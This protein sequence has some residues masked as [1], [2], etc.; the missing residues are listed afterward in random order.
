MPD[1]NVRP[2][3]IGDF[4]A[5]IALWRVSEGVGLNEYLL[6][7]RLPNVLQILA[8]AS[9][10]VSKVLA[11]LSQ[12]QRPIRAASHHI[13]ILVILTVILPKADWTNLE[14]ASLAQRAGTTART[15]IQDPVCM[16]FHDGTMLKSVLVTIEPLIA[17]FD[18]LGAWLGIAHSVAKMSNK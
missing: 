6:L 8:V 16:R 9:S 1:W 12:T 7:C 2:M 18:L 14:T 11:S 5:V 17:S 13:G 10:K 4:D 3:E 15:T